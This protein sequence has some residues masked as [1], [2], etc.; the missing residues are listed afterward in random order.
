MS[1]RLEEML[2][3]AQAATPGP[4]RV[5]KDTNLVWGACDPDDQ[6]SNGMGY[7]IA[8]CYTLAAS[9]AKGPTEYEG[10][11]NAQHIA[12]FNPRTAEALVKVALAAEAIVALAAE[13]H[14]EWDRDNDAR[15]GKILIALA[16]GIKGY[17]PDTDAFH[18]SLSALTAAMED[19]RNV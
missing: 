13:A 19:S 8:P 11:A 4:W 12:T 5:E 18:A 17:R 3:I 15:V 1:E 6:S 2:R 9:Y 14:A 10:L 7:A 16:G